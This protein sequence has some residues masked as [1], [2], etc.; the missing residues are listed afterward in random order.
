MNELRFDGKVAVVTGSGGNPGL[1]RAHALL[2]ASRG[3]KVVVNDIGPHAENGGYAEAASA[4]TVAAEIRALGGDAVADTNTVATES[5]ANAIVQTALDA[6]GH[7]DIVINNAA[8]CIL[9]GF[10]DVTSCDIQRT[11]DVNLMG[12]IWT[13]RAAW[14]HMRKRAYGRIVNITSSSFIGA[15]SPR[16]TIYAASKGGVYSVTRGLASEGARLGIRVNS[17]ITAAFTRMVMANHEDSSPWFDHDREKLR[18]DLT[19]PVVA[20]LA[21]EECSSSG[22]CLFTGGGVIQ[23]LEFE[24]VEAFADPGLTM[25]TVAQHWPDIVGDQADIASL[26]N[27]EDDPDWRIRPYNPDRIGN[28]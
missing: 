20:Y 1:G 5:G 17:V 6:Y 27:S 25:E 18:P 22:A 24:R 3:S 7:V 16:Q 23:R 28:S 15:G 21:H 8:L 9:A 11:I 2:L 10:E 4:E 14:P 13:S 12:P 19:S 26:L